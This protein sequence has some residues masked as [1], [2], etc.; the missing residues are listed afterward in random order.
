MLQIANPSENSESSAE[1][2][3][4]HKIQSRWWLA[5]PT[6]ETLESVEKEITFSRNVVAVIL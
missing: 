2:P 4:T 3:P 6:A 1:Y 5:L